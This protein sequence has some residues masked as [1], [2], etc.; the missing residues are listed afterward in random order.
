MCN[1]K[2]KSLIQAM[3][4]TI[5][6]SSLAFGPMV[7]SAATN[8]ENSSSKGNSVEKGE[9]ILKYTAPDVD[10]S[11]ATEEQKETLKEIGWKMEDG[12]LVQYRSVPEEID[13]AINDGYLPTYEEA[14]KIEKEANTMFSMDATHEDNKE[15]V[16]DTL[17]VDGKETKIKDGT[18]EVA[19]S[20][21]KIDVEVDENTKETVKKSQDG[22][23]RLVIEQDLGEVIDQMDNHSDHE[24]DMGDM[25]DMHMNM[26]HSNSAATLTMGT[27]G[28]GDTYKTGDWVHCNRFNGPKSDNRH[29]EKWKPQAVI[30]FY[31]SDCDYGA[32]R[33]CKSHANCNQKYRAAYCS[34][35]LGHSTKYHKHKS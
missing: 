8:L 30:N 13:K 5:V 12:V 29:L 6:S 15:D 25:H 21:D 33:Y 27:M 31:H 11:I 10:M 2:K 34:Y 17:V 35:K 22:K 16:K 1:L 32:L 23:Y 9:I 18:F 28:Y 3:F 20:P 7:A 4:L 14:E 26:N 24:G 19:G